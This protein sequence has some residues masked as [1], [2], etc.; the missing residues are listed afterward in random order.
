LFSLAQEIP[1]PYGQKEDEYDQTC[2]AL[3]S[4]NRTQWL[5]IRKFYFPL[6]VFNDRLYSL[7]FTRPLTGQAYPKAS[8]SGKVTVLNGA[9]HITKPVGSRSFPVKTLLIKDASHLH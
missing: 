6:A 9:H 7:Y 2:P 4:C 5:L 3:S 8:R 1:T